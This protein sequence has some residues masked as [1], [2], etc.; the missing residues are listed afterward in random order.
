MN[1]SAGPNDAW[2]PS[3]ALSDLLQRSA[4]LA[5]I[6]AFFA[7][8]GVLEV[9]TPVLGRYTVTEPGIQSLQLNTGHYLQTSPEYHLKRLLAAGAPDLVRIGPVFRQDESGRLH[10]PEF[11][12]VEWYRRGYVLADLM[13]EVAALVDLAL[14]VGNYHQL[15]Y[16]QLLL[17]TF[18][19]DHQAPLA[20]LQQATQSLAA[21]LPPGERDRRTLLDLLFAEACTRRARQQPHER[22]FIT[23]FPADQAALA[24]LVPDA[25]GRL[26]AAR[27]ELLVAGIELAN[28]YDELCDAAEMAQRMTRDQQRRVALGLPAVAADTRL[29]AAMAA[30]L[31]ACAGVALGF[32]RLLL[33][34]LGRQQLSQVLPFAG[35][36]A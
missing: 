26:L 14:G 34:R 8:A 28:G 24:R 4:L 11:T 1:T 18:N 12:L 10:N 17:A 32:D 29:L 27:F 5:Q 25:Q 23:H 33:L 6:R 21:P 13:Q 30:G 2:Q 9:D 35:D 22:L 36:S 19:L 16:D 7:A 31:P 20:Q 15:R 3:A